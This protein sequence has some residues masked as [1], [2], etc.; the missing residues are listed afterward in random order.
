VLRAD[1]P[2]GPPPAASA[3]AH[4]A[5]RVDPLAGDAHH[6]GG[7]DPASVRAADRRLRTRA[8]RAQRSTSAAAGPSREGATAPE[9]R[10]LGTATRTTCY[11]LLASSSSACRPGAASVE[12]LICRYPE[13][14]SLGSHTRDE[15]CC[16]NCLYPTGSPS[17]TP[18]NRADET[19]A[20]ARRVYA[21]VTSKPI[22]RISRPFV[23]EAHAWVEC[24]SRRA[25]GDHRSICATSV[26]PPPA[27]AASSPIV[28]P[29]SATRR[30]PSACPERP[31]S[32]S[33]L[34]EQ[35]KSDPGSGERGHSPERCIGRAGAMIVAA[36]RR[37][38]SVSPR[39]WHR[40]RPCRCHSP[41]VQA[42]RAASRRS[43]RCL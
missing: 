5:K 26:A 1:G 17:S 8:R 20:E 32:R 14:P 3:R 29:Y 39:T 24:D 40:S 21:T 41:A 35:N 43:S 15:S 16:D 30:L 37:T 10:S 11:L 2:R 25:Q 19:S 7:R 6:H 22:F 33:Q 23:C 38:P 18:T 13:L 28:R 42:Q 27:G 34:S 31:N 9:H 36:G 4:Q 12:T